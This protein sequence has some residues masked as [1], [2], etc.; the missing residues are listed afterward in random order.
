[1]SDSFLRYWYSL[2]AIILVKVEFVEAGLA[3]GL[4]RAADRHGHDQASS[5]GR[6]FDQQSGTLSYLSAVKTS[7]CEGGTHYNST[8]RFVQAA[9]SLL[10]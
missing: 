2:E 6:R 1:M 8:T 7:N 5:L 4:R 10:C 9:N 3:S